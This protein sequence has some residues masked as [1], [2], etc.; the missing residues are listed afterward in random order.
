MQRRKRKTKG[1]K[2]RKCPVLFL[3]NNMPQ[4][5]LMGTTGESCWITAK[6][7]SPEL[8][9]Y[10]NLRDVLNIIFRKK[11]KGDIEKLKNYCASFQEGMEKKY[12][13]HRRRHQQG[14]CSTVF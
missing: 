4:I 11:N 10:K 5:Y 9:Y 7:P 3:G 13:I 8:H 6:N 2:N 14:S 1:E 12:R